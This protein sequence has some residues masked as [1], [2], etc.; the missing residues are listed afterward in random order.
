MTRHE[1]RK[2]IADPLFQTISRRGPQTG[3]Q[4]HTRLPDLFPVE[5][6]VSQDR[7]CSHPRLSSCA[8]AISP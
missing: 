5:I 8:I 2:M 1:R 6:D 4:I 3:S 7:R